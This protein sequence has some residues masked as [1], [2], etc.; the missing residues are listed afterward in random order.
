MKRCIYTKDVGGIKK[1]T[2]VDL[3]EERSKALI[4]KGNVSLLKSKKKDENKES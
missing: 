2:H 4:K 1:G 3:T